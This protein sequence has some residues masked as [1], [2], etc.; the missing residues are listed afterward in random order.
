M[1]FQIFLKLKVFIGIPS[2]R[3]NVQICFLSMDQVWLKSPILE[4]HT[5]EHWGLWTISVDGAVVFNTELSSRS[6]QLI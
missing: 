1:Y 6:G 3:L 5:R 4:V 2:I